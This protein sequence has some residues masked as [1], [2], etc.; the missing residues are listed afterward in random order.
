M[1]YDMKRSGEQIRLLR[2]RRGY[3]QEE[4]AGLLNI[5]RSYYS[6]IESGKRGC[7][8]DMLVHLSSFLGVSLDYLAFGENHCDMT[9]SMDRFQLKNDIITLIS[10]LERF[11][12]Y[13]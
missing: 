2:M 7:S 4:I 12:D 5:D 1:N 8:V 3:T 11:K 10:Q 9:I 6:R 13:L